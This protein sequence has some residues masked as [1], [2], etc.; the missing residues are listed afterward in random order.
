MITV[1]IGDGPVMK[2]GERNRRLDQPAN[3]TSQRRWS[4]GLC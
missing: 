3:K 2:Q 4:A 1:Q